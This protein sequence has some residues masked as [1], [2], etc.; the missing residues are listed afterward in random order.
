MYTALFQIG[1]VLLLILASFPQKT[2][3]LINYFGGYIEETGEQ[4]ALP[5][6]HKLLRNL[7]GGEGVV[8][9]PL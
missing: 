3:I 1:S 5:S 9:P 4:H 8:V 2:Y 6:L 7:L